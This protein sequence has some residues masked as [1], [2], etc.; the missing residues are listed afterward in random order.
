[1]P[2]EKDSQELERASYFCLS[3]IHIDVYKRQT[4]SKDTLVF[5]M[6]SDP[7]TMNPWSGPMGPQLVLSCQSLEALTTYDE[8]GE[9]IPW[10][11]ESWEYDDDKMGC[12]FH[13]RQDVTFSN[14]N[15]FNADAVIYTMQ[16]AS[17]ESASAKGYLANVDVANVKKVDEFTVHI[18]TLIEFGTLPYTMSN[19]FIVDPAVYEAEAARGCLLYTSRCV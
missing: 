2:Y 18:P 11:A 15:P 13:L 9:L 10:L 5:A 12:T 7:G 8:S 1:M 17:A 19:I 3:L 4:S 16:T 6:N 14:G